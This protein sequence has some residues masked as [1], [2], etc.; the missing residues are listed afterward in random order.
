MEIEQQRWSDLARANL[1]FAAPKGASGNGVVVAD[2][3]GVARQT[4]LLSDG[5]DYDPKSA[6]GGSAATRS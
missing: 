5:N 1:A 3:T 6:G 4:F 2:D